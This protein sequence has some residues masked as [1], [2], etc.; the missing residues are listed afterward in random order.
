MYGMNAAGTYASAALTGTWTARSQ[1]NTASPSPAV[2]G[3][4]ITLAGVEFGTAGTVKFTTTGGGSVDGEVM[5]PGWGR[6]AL[7]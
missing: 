4:T 1:L 2:Q 5:A 3:Q 7:R 6:P